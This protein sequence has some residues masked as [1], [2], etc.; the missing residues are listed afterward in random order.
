VNETGA[1]SEVVL[2]KKVMW[3][4][5]FRYSRVNCST[6]SVN[7]PFVKSQSPDGHAFAAVRRADTSVLVS[8]RIFELAVA[9]KKYASEPSSGVF[10]RRTQPM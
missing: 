8:A 10:V 5:G 3:A 4:A 2:T 6:A 1:A 7:P 9:R